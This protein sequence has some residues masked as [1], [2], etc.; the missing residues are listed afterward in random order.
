MSLLFDFAKLK[1]DM[2]T[3]L[4]NEYGK[5][6]AQISLILLDIYSNDEDGILTVAREM[7]LNPDNYLL[8]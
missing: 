4:E 6:N 7:N 5:S 1:K 2:R 8:Y 3:V